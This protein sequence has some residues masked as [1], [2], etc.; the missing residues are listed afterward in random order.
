M[1]SLAAIFE[2][3]KLLAAI[4]SALIVFVI[5]YK[6]LQKP[7]QLVITSSGHIESKI[8][9]AREIIQ[10]KSFWI[11]Q[12]NF[13]TEK[14]NAPNET[15][16]LIELIN[17]NYELNERTLKAIETNLRNSNNDSIYNYTST[18]SFLLK[19]E[20]ERI[21][22]L[23]EKQK[24]IEYLNIIYKKELESQNDLIQIKNIIDNKIASYN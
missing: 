4:A 8:D 16:R 2:K 9:Q 20:S 18:E 19:K 13:I 24:S 3:K 7:D 21:L 15:L 1:K 11:S 17:R 14:L 22:R 23:S 12:L 6:L 5:S 10:G